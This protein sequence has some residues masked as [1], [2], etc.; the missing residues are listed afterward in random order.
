MFYS[1]LSI[2]ISSYLNDC[3]V[4]K[5]HAGVNPYAVENAEVKMRMMVIEGKMRKCDN[6][7]TPDAEY[8]QP[9]RAK[10]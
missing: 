1:S 2:S 3:A 4:T 5:Y 8:D 7:G 9:N 10:R 6:N